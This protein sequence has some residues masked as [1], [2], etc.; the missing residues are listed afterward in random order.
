MLQ[1]QRAAKARAAA[2]RA[3]RDFRNSSQLLSTR[4]EWDLNRPDALTLDRP[5]REGDADAR[6]GVSSMQTFG[7]EDLSAGSRSS[8]QKSQCN[9]W[10]EQQALEKAAAEEAER[11]ELA[12]SAALTRRCDEVQSAAAAEEAR[13]KREAH[14]ATMSEN[15]R[16]AEQRKVLLFCYPKFGCLV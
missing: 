11:A 1:E 5:A 12:A 13:I 15:A 6:C 8:A 14:A 4:R 9:E 2:A 7:G 3:E 10:W 16:L